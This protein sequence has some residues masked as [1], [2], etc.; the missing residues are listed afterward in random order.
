[1]EISSQILLEFCSKAASV[2]ERK[3]SKLACRVL[4]YFLPQANHETHEV[5]N[6]IF[7]V[8]ELLLSRSQ[9]LLKITGVSLRK[10]ECKL[11]MEKIGRRKGGG[12]SHAHRS[13][14][15]S[16]T[17][18]TG[19]GFW[20]ENLK[21]FQLVPE[22]P[23][24]GDFINENEANSTCIPDAAFERNKFQWAEPWGREGRSGC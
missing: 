17:G 1:M 21:T 22:S 8:L 9:H 18:M 14:V 13:S 5:K 6:N 24:L 4:F 16:T 20:L 12:R 23:L 11:V 19:A 15:A 3:K 7:I 2:R 10:Y